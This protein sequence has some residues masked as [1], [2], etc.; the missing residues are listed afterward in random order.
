MGV[1]GPAGRSCTY[2]H[3]IEDRVRNAIQ[4]EVGI[5]LRI[6]QGGGTERRKPEPRRHETEGLTEMTS[7]EEQDAIRT[8]KSVLSAD[9][10]EVGRHQDEGASP[11]DP[12]L[13]PESRDE[14]V[15]TP[16]VALMDKTMTVWQV[17]VD[18]WRDAVDV[19]YQH[20]CRQRMAGAARRRRLQGD[21]PHGCVHPTLNPPSESEQR[22]QLLKREWARAMTAPRAARQQHRR[23]I[24]R[25]FERR[26]RHIW[27][28]LLFNWT[29]GRVPT[30]ERLLAG[31][32]LLVVHIFCIEMK[33]SSP[34]SPIGPAFHG[35]LA[36][37]DYYL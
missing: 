32:T 5:N 3:G 31:F 34:Q 14:F 12:A 9:A 37:R 13:P 17:A 16:G 28:R 29:E 33:E 35:S 30:H 18:S 23:K 8:P 22:G 7:F 21:W 19:P 20:V 36:S 4:S 6:G 24:A 2:T 25:S 15:I 27:R 11:G 1:T 26:K 10:S